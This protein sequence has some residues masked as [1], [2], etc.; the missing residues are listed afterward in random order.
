M[1]RGVKGSGPKKGFK[2]NRGTSS[3]GMGDAIAGLQTAR[4]ALMAQHN[5]ITRQVGELDTMIARLGGGAAGGPAPA[6]ATAARMGGGVRTGQSK[7]R[8]GSLKDVIHGVLAGAGG[9]MSVKDITETVV[10][11]GYESKNKTLAKSVGI[12]LMDMPGVRR[13]GRGMYKL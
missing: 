9:P 13:I 12:A 5:E 2:S 3:G 10:S 7:F 4:A 8:P 11:S 6:R 1:P